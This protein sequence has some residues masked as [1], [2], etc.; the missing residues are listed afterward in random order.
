MNYLSVCKFSE[1]QHYKNRKPP[2]IK[3]YV[4]LLDPHHPLNE[5]PITTRY[6]FDRL[7]L[8]AA[9]YDNAIPNDSELIAKLLRMPPRACREG[10]AELMKGRWIKATRTKRRASK[11]ASKIAP[12]ETE[13]EREEEKEI[14]KS[15]N[16][17][18]DATAE[19]IIPKLLDALTDA[20]RLTETTVRKLV[21]RYGLVEGD[22]AWARE[23]ATGP[24]VQSPAGV[25]IAELVKR[26]KAKQQEEVA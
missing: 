12:T 8:L 1:Y 11:A 16:G 14:S 7:L 3:F 9:E 6:L 24:G 2:W 17:Y 10:L 4:T 22:L 13:T 19:F 23:C 20:D 21:R 25:A 26:G 5:L 18:V 15:S